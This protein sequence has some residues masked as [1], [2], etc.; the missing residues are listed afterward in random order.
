MKLIKEF[1]GIIHDTLVAELVL[2]LAGPIFFREQCLLGS[3]CM[4]WHAAPLI[5]LWQGFGAQ[6][7][8]F[9]TSTHTNTLF[10]IRIDIIGLILSNCS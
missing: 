2:V 1:K 8:I 5:E 3:L 9:Y 10:G 7:P 4:R 6:P